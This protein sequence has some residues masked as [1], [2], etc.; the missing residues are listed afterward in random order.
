MI[1]LIA[2]SRISRIQRLQMQDELIPTLDYLLSLPETGREEADQIISN[3][4]LDLPVLAGTVVYSPLR[5]HLLLLL[6]PQ[7][8][9]QQGAFCVRKA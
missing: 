3:L 4:E 6:S 8:F 5:L 9:G 2:I 7:L 1:G